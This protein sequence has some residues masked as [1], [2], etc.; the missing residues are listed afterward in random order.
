VKVK[1]ARDQ[2]VKQRGKVRYWPNWFNY[3]YDC[4]Y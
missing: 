3:L 2:R 4:W 1:M